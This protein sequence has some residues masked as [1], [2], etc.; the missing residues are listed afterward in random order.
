MCLTSFI[1]TVK[2]KPFPAVRKEGESAFLNNLG[3]SQNDAWK[4]S[5][6]E[7]TAYEGT[8]ARVLIRGTLVGA[9]GSA[10]AGALRTFR[11]WGQ[12]ETLVSDH[13]LAVDARSCGT[14]CVYQ[15]VRS[16]PRATASKEEHYRFFA[17][18]IFAQ[19]AR[20]AAAIL[21]LPAA[22]IVRVG[23]AVLFRADLFPVEP[24]PSNNQST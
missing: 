7:G 24:V 20:C 10:S 15:P 2:V 6:Y 5:A 8:T 12:P 22:D 18:L 17:A 3:T 9:L 13:R 4:L 16:S 14:V 23:R 19:R 11:E 21:F 1:I